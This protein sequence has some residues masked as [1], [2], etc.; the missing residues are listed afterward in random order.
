MY[1]NFQDSYFLI[2]ENSTDLFCYV[3]FIYIYEPETSILLYVYKL[4][5]LL[6]IKKP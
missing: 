2:V 6:S 5:I 4:Y 3:E 1:V